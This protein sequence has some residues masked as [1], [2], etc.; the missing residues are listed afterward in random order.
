MSLKRLAEGYTSSFYWLRFRWPKSELYIASCKKNYNVKQHLYFNGA[1]FII[2]FL[3]DP[4]VYY[5]ILCFLIS[6]HAFEK[7]A[8]C[9]NMNIVLKQ[10]DFAR[11][12]K[13]C[14]ALKAFHCEKNEDLKVKGFSSGEL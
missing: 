12:A 11:N 5:I 8:S 7:E 10:V 4:Y 9:I 6:E 2:V 1:D 13:K 3:N 14:C